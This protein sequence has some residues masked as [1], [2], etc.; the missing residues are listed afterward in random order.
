M[1]GF[2]VMNMEEAAKL[3]DLFVTVTGCRDII[4]MEHI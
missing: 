1:D 2:K 3:G 4:A